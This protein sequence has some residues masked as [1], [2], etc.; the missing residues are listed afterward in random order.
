MVSLDDSRIIV[1]DGHVNQQMAQKINPN[2][3]LCQNYSKI[4]FKKEAA[5]MNFNPAGGKELSSVDWNTES[6]MSVNDRVYE[7]SQGLQA[8]RL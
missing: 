8:A 3:G 7:V 6:K 5:P 1:D 2:S 4:E